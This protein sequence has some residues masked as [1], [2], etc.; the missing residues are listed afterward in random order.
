MTLRQFSFY[1]KRSWKSDWLSS[2]PQTK[3]S[4]VGL[5]FSILCTLLFLEKFPKVFVHQNS[6]GNFFFKYIYIYIN[7]LK[8]SIYI[9]IYIYI[10]QVVYF[11]LYWVIVAVLRLSLVVFGGLLLAG[12][13][14]VAG[15]KFSVQGPGSVIVVSRLSCPMAY[16]LFQDQGSNPCPL[17]CLSQVSDPRLILNQ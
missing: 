15:Y 3:R 7:V 5:R 16:G 4:K 8:W 11:W 1:V 14:L 13:P 2:S 12:A 6:L 17:Y 10:N 9:Y